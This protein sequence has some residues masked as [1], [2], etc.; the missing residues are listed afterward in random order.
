MLSIEK[1]GAATECSFH[2]QNFRMCGREC[3]YLVKGTKR[4][5]KLWQFNLPSAADIIDAGPLVTLSKSN[6]WNV[7]QNEELAFIV[8]PAISSKCWEAIS[9]YWWHVAPP[10]DHAKASLFYKLLTCIMNFYVTHTRNHYLFSQ[11]IINAIYWNTFFKSKFTS[12]IL[13]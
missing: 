4:G 5:A 9:I 10:G 3:C 6:L 2:L 7:C 1:R 12:F 13:Y 8:R 11:V